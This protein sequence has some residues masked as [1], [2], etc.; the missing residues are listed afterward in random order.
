MNLNGAKNKFV[1]KNLKKIIEKREIDLMFLLETF[2]SLKKEQELREI[3]ID[4]DV[5]TNARKDQYQNANYKERGGIA[6]IAR[7]GMTTEK[8]VE[9]DDLIWLKVGSIEVGSA[10]FVHRV[11]RLLSLTKVEWRNCSNSRWKQVDKYLL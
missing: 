5:Y 3:F 2:I 7:K 4:Y 1:M 6:A 11:P 9:S 8:K 10:Y